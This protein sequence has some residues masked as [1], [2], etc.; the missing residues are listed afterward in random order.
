MPEEHPPC[1]SVVVPCYNEEATLTT[2]VEQVLASPYTAEVLIVD[3]GST[4]GTLD[5][6]RTITD[7]R[8]RVLVHDENRGKGASLRWGLSEATSEF[9]IIQDADLEYD[10][11]EYDVVL[12]PLL[13]GKADVVYGSRFQTSRP[14]RV[15]YYWHSVGNRFLTTLSNMCTN[16]NLSD[17]ET[18]YKAFRRDVLDTIV[19]EEER[20]GFEPEI[21]AKVARGPWRV[22]EVGISYSGR[23]YAE[24]KK[25]GW[26]DGVRS[27]WCILRYSPVVDRRRPAPRRSPADFEAADA[28]LSEALHSLGEAPNYTA[29]I[30]DLVEP[31]LGAEILEVGAGR[32]DLTERFR[33]GRKVTAVDLSERCLTVLRER[34]AHVPDVDVRR[35]DIAEGFGSERYDSIVAVNVLE[36][37]DD[38]VGAVR[39]LAAALRPGGTL[40]LWV[41]ALE[42]LYST[43]DH[44]IGHY[45]RYD[46][47]TLAE[48][49]RRA[50]L[51]PV[52]LRYVNA[53]GGIMWWVFAR[54][55][56]AV[57]TQRWTVR[58]FDRVAMPVVRQ[59]ESR[60]SPP[61][62]QS[63]LCVA[64]A[65][66]EV[67]DEEE[68]AA[69]A[70]ATATH[71][72]DSA[73][74][75]SA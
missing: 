10:P 8:V 60:W 49:I 13:D 63:L 62:G 46:R 23:T 9:V 51:E 41:P 56:G 61:L 18:C 30:H 54:R 39:E 48:V 37:I 38:H 20:F 66:R 58:L 72:S 55:L 71:Q 47:R 57:P 15:V 40:I 28:E 42:V 14:H 19:I 12:G 17:M 27:L 65:R 21:T 33:V 67:G 64:R 22:Y 70:P 29:W 26:R 16:L 43:F 4:D 75:V 68:P 45:R 50:G 74:E 7:P 59:L 1:L 44:A 2:V 34:F 5:A 53:A 36:H 24:G 25:I 73:S 35:V 31:H 69:P 6:A 32:G 11:R 3:D 52:Q